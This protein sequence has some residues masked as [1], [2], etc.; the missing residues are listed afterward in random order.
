[1]IFLLRGMAGPFTYAGFKREAELRDVNIERIIGM[2]D[3][4]IEK[5]TREANI[6]AITT[7]EDILTLRPGDPQNE[8]PTPN[9]IFDH[10]HS[11]AS[12]SPPSPPTT[13]LTAAAVSTVAVVTN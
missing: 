11:E 1:M 6:E 7:V 12:I 9:H 2:S 5:V 8:V 10:I 3:A 4:S 13:V